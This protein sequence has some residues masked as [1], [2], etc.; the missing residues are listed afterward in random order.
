MPLRTVTMSNVEAPEMLE[1]V[2]GCLRDIGYQDNLLLPNYKFRDFLTNAGGFNG[3]APEIELAA[4][5]Q[6]PPSYRSACFGVTVPP[7]ESPQSIVRF[8][9]LGAPQILAL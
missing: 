8:R 6:S 2:R 3:T 5:A 7:D 9:A 1:V 4:F